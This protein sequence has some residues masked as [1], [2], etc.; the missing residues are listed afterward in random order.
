MGPQCPG[1]FGHGGGALAGVPVLT[2]I[3]Q[4]SRTGGSMPRTD[5][6]GSRPA[7]PAT[8]IPTPIPHAAPMALLVHR[9][10]GGHGAS[11][12]RVSGLSSVCV[13]YAAQVWTCSLT[14]STDSVALR[15]WGVEMDPSIKG[16]GLG[17]H[18]ESS[19]NSDSAPSEWDEF[20]QITFL[21]LSF[22]IYYGRTIPTL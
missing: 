7:V 12:V 17:C 22:L 19:L 8:P 3:C 16:P 18:L 21:S 6:I 9:P 14:L 11:D 5:P 13:L 10:W 2:P 1:W 4:G 20:G 15:F